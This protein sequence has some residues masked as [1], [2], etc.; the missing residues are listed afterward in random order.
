MGKNDDYAR[1]FKGNGGNAKANANG[2]GMKAGKL[3]GKLTGK[4]NTAV[5][6]RTMNASR[7]SN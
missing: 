6:P 5:K 1:F 4:L 7:K 3:T 2:Q